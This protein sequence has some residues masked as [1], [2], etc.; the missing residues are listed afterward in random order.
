MFPIENVFVT[1]FQRLIFIV[2][3]Q[4]TALTLGKR[5]TLLIPS[6][7]STGW[8]IQRIKSLIESEIIFI[9]VDLRGHHTAKFGFSSSERVSVDHHR[10][11]HVSQADQGVFH[12]LESAPVI[13]GGEEGVELH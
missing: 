10:W 7:L 11:K 5:E 4:E 12:F 6:T 9:G 3:S 1:F 8:L 13:D 2:E